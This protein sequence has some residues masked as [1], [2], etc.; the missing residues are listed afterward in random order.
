SSDQPVYSHFGERFSSIWIGH[1]SWLS[2]PEVVQQDIAKITVEKLEKGGWNELHEAMDMLVG[3]FAAFIWDRSELRIY[4][5]ATAIRPVYFNYADGLV[6][7]H[8]PLLRE[9][10]EGLGKDLRPTS[11]VNQFKLWEETE[12]LDI[13]ALP[14]NFY[15]DFNAKTIH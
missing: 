3:R 12:D 9:L 15:I 6:T 2:E 5:D 14:P 7:S 4:H 13:S 10:R 11:K 8:A 1:G